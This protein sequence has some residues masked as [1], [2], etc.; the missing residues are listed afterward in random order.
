ML[1]WTLKTS[2]ENGASIGRGSPAPT[3]AAPA[4]ARGRSR[5]SSRSSTPKFETPNRRRP[6]CSGRRR[7]PRGRAGCRPRRAA[8]APRRPARHPARPAPPHPGE[9]LLG[10]GVAPPRGAAET[11][12][13]ARPAI[14][15]AAEVTGEA[16]RPRHRRRS[17]GRASARCGRACQRIHPRSVVLVDEGEQ[18]DSASPG[19]L[20]QPQGLRLDALR[21]VE[22]HHRAVGRRQHPQCVLG[23]VVV[24]GRVEQ[25]EDDPGVAEAQHGRGDRDPALALELHPVRRRRPRGCRGRGPRRPR[26]P[27]RRRAAA[28]R[29]ASSC[30]R[31]GGR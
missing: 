26:R 4:P 28:S 16:D 20:E 25:V 6:E 21:G 8:R 11:V 7:T 18:R 9:E 17:G 2:P 5:A 24:P 10:L 14:D 31:P 23:E 13:V 22:Q 12:E 3:R 15:D 19:D 29:S 27:R 1:A 30:R